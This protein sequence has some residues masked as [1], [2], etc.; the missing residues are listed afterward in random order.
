MRSRTP[1]NYV[2]RTHGPSLRQTDNRK[3]RR[4]KA[5]LNVALISGITK[6][7]VEGKIIRT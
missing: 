6:M 2:T 5:M 3:G 4:A 7:N 1:D